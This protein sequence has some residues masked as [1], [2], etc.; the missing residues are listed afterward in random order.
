MKDPLEIF[1]YVQKL[2]N[3]AISA[4]PFRHAHPTLHNSIYYSQKLRECSLVEGIQQTEFDT[5]ISIDASADIDP[6]KEHSL[7]VHVTNV[8][9]EV[10]IER[11]ALTLLTLVQDQIKHMQAQPYIPP[12]TVTQTVTASYA[13]LQFSLPHNIL[14]EFAKVKQIGN[15]K[16]MYS[17]PNKVKVALHREKC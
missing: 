6:M 14:K 3:P 2:F 9:K 5:V 8:D 12:T 11:T 7:M 13:L 15:L 1:M 17:F 10:F 16:R 4:K